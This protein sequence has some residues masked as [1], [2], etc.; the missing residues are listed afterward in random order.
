MRYLDERRVSKVTL[1]P[2]AVAGDAVA[3]AGRDVR[4]D[5]ARVVTKVTDSL[6]CQRQVVSWHDCRCGAKARTHL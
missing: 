6:Q 1:S 3:T 5:Q 2:T 4:G